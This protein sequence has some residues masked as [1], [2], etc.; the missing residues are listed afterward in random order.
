[1][2]PLGRW[3]LVIL[4]VASALGV[5][6]P[7]FYWALQE[8]V[9]ASPS[10]PTTVASSSACMPVSSPSSSSPQVS[11][12]PSISFFVRP[13]ADPVEQQIVHI[14]GITF[15]LNLTKNFNVVVVAPDL[16]EIF[17]FE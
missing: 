17:C 14:L 12:Y 1:V 2:V 16:L 3:C 7:A 10:S 15:F 6:D 5:T 9:S 13:L 4:V 11:C 8:G